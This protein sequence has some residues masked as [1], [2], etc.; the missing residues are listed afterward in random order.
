MQQKYI[1]L[2]QY[3]MPSKTMLHA[4]HSFC[5]VGLQQE[6]P[7]PLIPPNQDVFWASVST[8]PLFSSTWENLFQE[9]Q[10]PWV[11]GARAVTGL[12]FCCPGAEDTGDFLVW[13]LLA[14]WCG[15]EGPWTGV[16]SG[17]PLMGSGGGEGNWG[18]EG[19]GRGGI[20]A[21][22]QGSETLR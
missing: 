3:S 9:N 15:V 14:Q 8:D 17:W 2:F 10:S 21:R 13:H 20:P 11:T 18:E 5:A 12:G 4:A 22:R 19:N 7:S 1:Q 6:S 16:D